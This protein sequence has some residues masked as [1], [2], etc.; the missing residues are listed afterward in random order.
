M[1]LG[2]KRKEEIELMRLI[3]KAF[4]EKCFFSLVTAKYPS[5]HS[6][7]AS[8]FF[9]DSSREN[10]RGHRDPGTV[11]RLYYEILATGILGINVRYTYAF[12]AIV[13]GQAFN[14]ENIR[15]KVD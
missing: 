2:K 1:Q 15:L 5:R 13:I 4:P 14:S 6:K 3:K 9:N 7:P 12:L 10:S 8:V 11:Q